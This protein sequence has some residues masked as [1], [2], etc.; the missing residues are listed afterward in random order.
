MVP[1]GLVNPVGFEPTHLQGL[2]LFPTANWDTGP[3]CFS[4]SF[5]LCVVHVPLVCL[6]LSL[7]QVVPLD[8]LDKRTLD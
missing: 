6:Q 7:P 1:L 5:G 3:D 2:S 4:L 8:L